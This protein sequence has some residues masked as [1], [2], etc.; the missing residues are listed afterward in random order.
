MHINIKFLG[1][2]YMND[3]HPTIKNHLSN[4]PHMQAVDVL[5]LLHQGE[6]GAGHLMSD[7][8]KSLDMLNRELEIANLDSS[9]CV[10][11]ISA[12]L[13]RLHLKSV[14]Q[15]G[16]N[17]ET[18]NKLFI[19]TASKLR[20]SSDAFL[21]KCESAAGLCAALENAPSKAD[22]LHA[23]ESWQKAGGGV[24]SHSAEYKAHYKPAYRVVER[25]YTD[26]Y[27]LF[28][29]KSTVNV[30][31]DGNCAGGKTTLGFILN[32]VYGCHTIHMDHF[33]LPFEMR[34]KDRLSQPGGNIDYDR[35]AKEVAT[36]LNKGEAFSYRPYSCE[37]GE[38]TDA[39]NIA[40]SPINVVEGSYSMHPLFADV[41]D[42][43]VFLTVDFEEQMRRIIMRNGEE[44]SLMFKDRWIPL[45]NLYF[46]HFKVKENCD[47]V[48]YT[49]TQ[50]RL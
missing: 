42:I 3:I 45:E 21:H 15:D 30:A 12:D 39:I 7:E 33:F 22:I 34:S 28:C 31:I 35:F 44:M 5:K 40:Q 25:Q 19:L 18:L 16:L 37:T 47:L 32:Q 11:N 1:D 27:G 41:Y 6:F 38:F 10:E 49:C 4:Y 9:P 17:I 36:P 8:K 13:C 20:G 29:A 14:L 50:D 43:K 46:E 26:F 2:T 48:F 23:A 24:F